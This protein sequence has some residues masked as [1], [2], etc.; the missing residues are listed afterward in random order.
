MI[1][2]KPKRS[3]ICSLVQPSAFSSTVTGWR[4]LRSMRTPTVARLSTSN[5]S[6][7]PRPGMTLTL[8]QV[9]LGGLVLALVE[10]DAGRAD[11][12]G[13]HDTLGAVDDEGALLGHHREVAHEDRLALDLAGGVVDELRGDEQRRRVGLVLLLAVVDGCLDLVEARIGEAQRQRAREVL[14]RRQLREHLFEAADGGRPRRAR[15]PSRASGRSRS[16]TRRSPSARR[17]APEP[18]EARGAWRR[19]LGLVLQER[20]CWGFLADF[21]LARDCQDASFQHLMRLSETGHGRT[22]RR[23]ICVGS[24]GVLKTTCLSGLTH[25]H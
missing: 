22:L 1:S 5:S 9:V 2:E 10:V 16:A 12:L 13:H 8:V 7:A 17:A 23:Y 21:A 20:S 3:V 18:R 15:A 19:K 11:Q 14:D 25:A 4:R 6:H 24:A